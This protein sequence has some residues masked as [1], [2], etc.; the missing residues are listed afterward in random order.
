MI[1]GTALGVGQD[2]K[3]GDVEV[4]VT[5]KS[6]WQAHQCYA[7]GC[8]TMVAARLWMC[9]HHWLQV[10]DDIRQTMYALEDEFVSTHDEKIW[11]QYRAAGV[12]AIAHVTLP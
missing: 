7:K 12:R 4:V 6:D 11:D 3:G 9:W 2:V 5:R 8:H 10:P 1:S